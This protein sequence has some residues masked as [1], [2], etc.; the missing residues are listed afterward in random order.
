MSAAR[1]AANDGARSDGGRLAD[2]GIHLKRETPGAYRAACPACAKGKR[3]DALSVT[4]NVPLHT[5]MRE[6]LQ[7]D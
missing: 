4:I 2:H 7:G 5:W 6:L 1:E 3:D